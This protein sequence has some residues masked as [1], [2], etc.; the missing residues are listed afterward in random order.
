MRGADVAPRRA[1]ARGPRGQHL[2]L[3]GRAREEQRGARGEGAPHPRGPGRA[4]AT[5]ARGA[6]DAG[7]ARRLHTPDGA[8]AA[9]SRAEGAHPPTRISVELVEFGS[10]PRR[11]RATSRSRS[12]AAGINPSDAKAMLGL[13]PSAVFPRTPG[14]DFA[15][16][17][18][19]GPRELVGLEVWGSRR[20]RRHLAQRL[21]RRAASCCPRAA[22]RA[23]AE[24]AF[25]GRGRHGR[26]A[27]RDGLR[28]VPP[29]R[30]AEAGRRGRGLRRERQGRAR[31]RCSSRSRAGAQVFAVDRR[32]DAPR[33]FA[34]R[35]RALHRL[36]PRESRPR[37]SARRP[38]AAARTSSTTPSAARTS[39]RPTRAMAKRGTQVFI[40]THRPRG[41]FRHLRVLS[42]HAHVCRHRFARRCS[43]ADCAPIF[44][45]LA[46]GFEDGTLQAFPAWRE[47]HFALE[48]AVDAYR[49][50]LGG[51]PS[52]RI[53]TEEEPMKNQNASWRA[54]SLA[55]PQR[56]PSR[57]RFPDNP[58]H[59]VVPFTRA[60]A[61]TSSRA[62]WPSRCRARSGSRSSSRTSPA[63]AARWA[64]RRSRRARPT[65]TRC[66]CIRP[67]HVANPAIYTSLP[68]DTLK[69][70]AGVTP[71]AS[72]PNVL[73]VSPSKGYK[74]RAGPGRKRASESGQAQLRLRGHRQRH[75][76]ERGDLPPRP[77][78]S[79]RVHVPFKGT[80]EAMTETATGRIDFFFAPLSSALPLIKDGR[81]QALAVGTA[82]RS[83]L[84]PERADHGRGGL[85]R[86]PNT[87]SG[88]RCSHPPG[89]RSAVVDRLNAEALKALA[90]PEVKEKLAA[91]GAEP[92]PMSPAAFDAFLRVG[93]RAHGGGREGRRHQGAMTCAPHDSHFASLALR[94]RAAHGPRSRS[95]VIVFPGGVQLAALGRA[96]TRASSP[97]QG[98][99]VKITPTPGSVFLIA[100][101]RGGQVRHRVHDVR[102]RGGVQE[103]QGEAPLPQPPDFFAFMGGQYG[104]VRLVAQPGDQDDRRP[105]GQ[106]ARGGRGDDRLCIRA[107]QDAAA[108][109]LERRRLHVR[110]SWAARVSARRRSCRA[111]PPR[112]SS[113]RRSRSFPSRKGYR[114]LANATETSGPYQAVRGVARR[115]W[116]KD[117]RDRAGGLHPAYLAGA[118]LARRS[119]PIA[120]R[121]SRSTASTFPRRARHRRRRRGKCSRTSGEGF[122]EARASSTAPAMETVL[123]LRSE[124]GRPQKTLT[125]AD[126]Y[127]DES[128]YLEAVR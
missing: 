97:T 66:S 128:Y 120:P 110:A 41:A 13:M 95:Q 29:Q 72:L 118:A 107:A 125:D 18:V 35:P 31:R 73:I 117:A 77:R 52:A 68:Y 105:Q 26:R 103:G 8:R 24:E 82:Q 78:S 54:L 11:A 79:T 39:P 100:E 115:S 3:E 49:K 126:K 70:F 44:E 9:T 25:D 92:M 34:S 94:C 86:S 81:L 101:P 83:P 102:Q 46:P 27:V 91:L 96:R 1:R 109:G 114:R 74:T 90:S 48:Q 2:S 45:A 14:R 65:A 108:G 50:V 4:V 116:A 32:A 19:E 84:L 36:E 112:P 20:R 71:L 59:F 113:P 10:Q 21:A 89:R 88:W 99:E 64:R 55:L 63:R 75:A 23:Q 30:Y 124:F 28:R 16:V 51:S 123:K 122:A 37:S 38:A 33:G 61:P 60:A 93:D 22:I 47:R 111:R 17:V 119:R 127:V 87:S 58:I 67:G 56:R 6:R 76:H 106:V 7:P 40:A 12:H 121:R 5:R 15:G 80:P 53:R 69:D 62:P 98:L 85:S 57:R 43:A 104:G 42:R